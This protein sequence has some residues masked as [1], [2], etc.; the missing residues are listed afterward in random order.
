MTNGNIKPNLVWMSPFP[1]HTPPLVRVVDAR[2]LVT[3]KY[4]P[5]ATVKPPVRHRQC[6]VSFLREHSLNPYVFAGAL[7]NQ[8]EI[9]SR[10]WSRSLR[11]SEKH[12]RELVDTWKGDADGIL[13]FVCSYHIFSST[14]QL[15]CLLFRRGFFLPL[16][17]ASS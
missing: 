1:Q 10:F 17:P 3:H 4:P 12:D 9:A 8:H 2:I 16:W 6:V 11:K 14:L 15:I 5:R 7:E 13:I